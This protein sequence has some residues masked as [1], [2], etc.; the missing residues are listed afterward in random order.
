MASNSRS[1]NVEIIS[2]TED[3]CEFLLFDTDASVANALR[4]IIIS[5]VYTLAID[6]VEFESNT[7][8][9]T[10][11][12]LAHRLGL[13]P[14][15]SSNVDHF[16]DNRE[17]TMCQKYCHVCSVEFRLSV[18]CDDE[19]PKD[20]TSR[21][22]FAQDESGEVMPVGCRRDMEGEAEG[23]EH[24]I[25]ILKLRKNQEITLK[26][27]AKKGCAKE[28]AKWSPIS[29]C[30]FHPEPNVEIS[31][32]EFEKLT[33]EQKDKWVNTCPAGGLKYDEVTRQVEIEDP[34]KVAHCLELLVV[35]RDLQKPDLIKVDYSSDR[36]IF[37]IET[38]GAL[39]PEECVLAALKVLKEK[40][41]LINTSLHQEGEDSGYADGVAKEH[42]L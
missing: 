42:G 12:F 4:R 2:L 7:S 37:R 34:L 25:L 21:D 14:L 23:E 35:A 22:L 40:L 32:E 20:V 41:I 11:E 18:R 19:M 28:H 5:E 30:Y 10:D 39:K 9:L 24:G 8:V 13:I 27:I 1:P 29:S 3:Y 15:V 17:C 31:Q 26:A 38:T 33:E 36:F 16:Q 6:L